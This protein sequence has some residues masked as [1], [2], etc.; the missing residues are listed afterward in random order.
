MKSEYKG[1]CWVKK[2]QGKWYATI[3]QGGRKHHLGVFIEEEAA[4]RAYG[5]AARELNGASGR[6]RDLNFP[7]DEE[8]RAATRA[9]GSH[10]H[11]QYPQSS[12]LA[13]GAN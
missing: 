12:R 4:A 3:R 1:V 10:G 9:Q 7:T 5:K 2:G 8:G 6:Q 13:R 11:S